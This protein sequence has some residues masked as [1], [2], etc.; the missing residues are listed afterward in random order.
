[1]TFSIP[2]CKKTTTLHL[3]HIAGTPQK[4][5]L[6]HRHFYLTTFVNKNIAEKSLS[7]SLQRLV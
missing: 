7:T 2:Q 1:M 3:S 4:V 6:T 5:G